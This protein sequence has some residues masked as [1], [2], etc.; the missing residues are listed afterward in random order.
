MIH[1]S[2]ALPVHDEQQ[3]IS[4]RRGAWRFALAAASALTICLAGTGA[5]AQIGCEGQNATTDSGARSAELAARVQQETIDKA[6]AKAG[7]DVV[8]TFAGVSISASW[9]DH[10]GFKLKRPVQQQDCASAPIAPINQLLPFESTTFSASGLV[11]WDLTKRLGLSDSHLFKLGV[12]IGG[13]GLDTKYSGLIRTPSAGNPNIGVNV[14]N[15]NLSEDGVQIDLYSL[16][17]KG[18]TYF[19]FASSLGLGESKIKNAT[20]TGALGLFG[21]GRGETDYSDYAASGVLGHVFTIGTH[22]TSRVLLD[23]SGGLLY[24]NY[25]REGFTDTAGVRFSDAETAEF[26]GKLEAKLA[27]AH[28]VGDHTLTPYLKL[29]VKH[30]FDFDSNVT[31]TNPGTGVCVVPPPPGNLVVPCPIPFTATYDLT[32]DNTFWRI[33]GGFAMSFKGDQQTGVFEIYHDGSGDSSEI[34]GRAQYVVKLN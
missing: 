26:S 25:D 3:H 12:A 9:V 18:P 7:L 1:G 16:I 14:A 33:G 20:F 11:E 24:A 29:G 34:G 15:G 17:A 28:V 23:L 2:G 19:I 27:L 5:H 22:G 4:I 13:K 10:D 31:V 30:R 21:G 32:S 6:K 8:P